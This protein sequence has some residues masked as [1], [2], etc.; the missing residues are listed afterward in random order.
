MVWTCGESRSEPRQ[1]LSCRVK[2]TGKDHEEVLQD[3]GCTIWGLEEDSL[4]RT[5]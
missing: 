1:A 3:S 4:E 5:K 2:L